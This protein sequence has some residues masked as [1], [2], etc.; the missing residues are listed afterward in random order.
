MTCNVD[1]PGSPTLSFTPAA[2]PANPARAGRY[3][4]KGTHGKRAFAARLAIK[5]AA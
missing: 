5:P 2:G 4:F 3:P 1:G